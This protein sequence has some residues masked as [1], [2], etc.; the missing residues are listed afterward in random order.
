MLAFLSSDS[1]CLLGLFIAE[2][3]R[4]CGRSPD[5]GPSSV[6]AP[7]SDSSAAPPAVAQ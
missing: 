4:V 6:P 1:E 7:I 5:F 2:L 3:H